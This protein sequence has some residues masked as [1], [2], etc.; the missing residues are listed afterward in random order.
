MVEAKQF[1]CACGWTVISP[2]GEE[3]TLKY[4]KMHADEY[5]SD[6]NLGPEQL[7]GSIKTVQIRTE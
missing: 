1:T 3:D 5:H 4:A 7:R 2:V 6:L